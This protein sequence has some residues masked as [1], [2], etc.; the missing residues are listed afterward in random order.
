MNQATKEQ[1]AVEFPGFSGDP[2]SGPS[3]PPRTA[4]DSH[5]LSTNMEL[6]LLLTGGKLP[7]QVERHFERLI[8]AGALV[9]I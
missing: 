8:E 7:R 3:E 2:E 1:M 4:R 9:R 5:R 6:G